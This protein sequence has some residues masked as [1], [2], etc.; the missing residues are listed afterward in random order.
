MSIEELKNKA[1]KAWVD[2]DGCIQDDKEMWINGYLVGAL[3]NQ[4][5]LPSEEE[6]MK[7]SFTINPPKIQNDYGND[8]DDNIQYRDEWVDG[9]K[10]VIEHFKQQDNG[11]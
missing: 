1:E 9:A 10:W 11:K 4:I 2:C 6:I 8:Y 5:E 7:E 3:S